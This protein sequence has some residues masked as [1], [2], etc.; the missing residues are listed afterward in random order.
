MKTINDTLKAQPLPAYVIE[1]KEIEDYDL[2]EEY[3]KEIDIYTRNFIK[4]NNCNQWNNVHTEYPEYWE[5]IK[6]IRKKY[7]LE[8][9]EKE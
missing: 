7:G 8:E 4:A 9:L 1:K 2:N 3:K 5:G 6:T